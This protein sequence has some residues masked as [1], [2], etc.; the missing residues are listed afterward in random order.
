MIICN[1]SFIYISIILLREGYALL[2]CFFIQGCVSN[3][4]VVKVQTVNL[5]C[6]SS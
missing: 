2:K 3:A 6:L 4:V 5:A 1:S